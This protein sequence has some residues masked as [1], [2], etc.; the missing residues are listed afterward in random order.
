MQEQEKRELTSESSERGTE[1]RP[2]WCAC[3]VHPVVSRAEQLPEVVGVASARSSAWAL[4]RGGPSDETRVPPLLV[5]SPHHLLGVFPLARSC[6]DHGVLQIRPFAQEGGRLLIPE[7][8]VE[9]SAFHRAL[10]AGD[11]RF[12]R[13]G[14]RPRLTGVEKRRRDTLLVKPSLD[15]HRSSLVGEQLLRPV[16]RSPC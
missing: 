7:A 11:S 16:E 14:K 3:D 12:G 15:E 9:Q 13:I 10:A 1:Q 6:S 2:L 4:A 8:D 5:F